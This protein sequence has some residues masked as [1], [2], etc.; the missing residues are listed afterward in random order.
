MPLDEANRRRYSNRPNGGIADAF[1]NARLNGVAEANASR[2]VS[3]A[4]GVSWCRRLRSAS[5][6]AVD[7]RT[8]VEF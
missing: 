5:S 7:G 1:R 2:A 4:R 3:L 6:A 8:R